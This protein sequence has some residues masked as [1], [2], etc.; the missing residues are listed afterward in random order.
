MK[1]TSIPLHLSVDPWWG[2]V[3]ALAFGRVDDGLPP[4]QMLVL[5]E[6]ERI[7]LVL[8]RPG[9]GPVIGFIG[10]DPEGIDVAALES[11]EIW[12]GPRFDVPTISL[13]GASVGEILLAVRARFAEGEP[14]AGAM[15]FHMAIGTIAS[16]GREI[17]D[18]ET[19]IDHW[20]LALEAGESKALFGLGYTLAEVGRAREAYDLLRRYTELTPHNAWA[21]CWLGRACLGTGDTAEARSAFERALS[22]EE[23]GSFETDAGDLLARLGG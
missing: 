18:F 23:Q 21:W 5:E 4:D 9:A 22:C 13:S 14:T 11:P 2:L 7:I 6:D 17:S 8:D 10:R 19:A 3:S 20:R 12:D 1:A 15:H 16:N